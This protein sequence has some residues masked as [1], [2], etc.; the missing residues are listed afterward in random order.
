MLTGTLTSTL[1]GTLTNTLAD[2]VLTGT[3]AQMTAEKEFAVETE[4]CLT[5]QAVRFA[6][7]SERQLQLTGLKQDNNCRGEAD[8]KDLI[9]RVNL[10]CGFH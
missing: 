5:C 2:T 7:L 6:G 4:K 3:V 1:T 9:V 8:L 10:I